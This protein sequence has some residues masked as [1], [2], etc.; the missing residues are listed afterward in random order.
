M[1]NVMKK[2]L[3]KRSAG[4]M[5][6]VSAMAKSV[7][8]KQVF[9]ILIII[10]SMSVVRCCATDGQ[11]AKLVMK[12]NISVAVM[13][14]HDKLSVVA[15]ANHSN[16]QNTSELH[17]I[18]KVMSSANIAKCNFLSFFSNIIFGYCCKATV[19]R[20]TPSFLQIYNK[21]ENDGCYIVMFLDIQY[22]YLCMQ[23][24][25]DCD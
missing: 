2:V 19:E 15:G 18:S 12:L 22:V 1:A 7:K 3:G 4:R 8:S 5:N 20:V 16:K 17:P 14:S 23:I 24:R 10:S 21:N 9:V 11:I 13:D 6:A 25:Y